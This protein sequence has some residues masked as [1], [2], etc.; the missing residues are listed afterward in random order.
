ML[1]EQRQLDGVQRRVMQLRRRHGR[2][3]RILPAGRFHDYLKG[4]L[5]FRRSNDRDARFDNTRLLS[6]D[7]G[8]RFSQP[9][10]MIVLNIGNDA[11]QGSNDIG[12]V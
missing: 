4:F 5:T 7:T 12:G 10:L 1:A 9:L 11:D 2:Q 8:Q 6:G 3:R